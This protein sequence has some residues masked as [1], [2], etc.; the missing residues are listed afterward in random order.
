MSRSNAGTAFPSN[1]LPLQPV[2]ENLYNPH[3][4]AGGSPTTPPHPQSDLRSSVGLGSDP[5][6][7]LNCQ[8]VSAGI[9][10]QGVL[11]LGSL[12][13]VIR[14]YARELAAVYRVPVEL[15][16]I[17]MLGTLSAAIG[18]SRQAINAVPE[19]ITRA[20]L[21]LLVSLSSGA[22][23]SIS[24]RIAKPFTDFEVNATDR[25]E[26][27]DQPRLKSRQIVLEDKLKCLKKASKSAPMEAPQVEAIV[28]ELNQLTRDMEKSPVLS[29]GNFTTTGLGNELA[30]TRDETL[31]VFSSEGG[32]IVDVMLGESKTRA[33]HLQLW[34]N[35][36]SGEGYSQVRAVLSGGGGN[37]VSLKDICLSA[38]LMVQ[39]SVAKKLM[40]HHSARER[41]LLGR[42]LMVEVKAPPVR[43]TGDRLKVSP[44]IEARWTG[45]V[46]RIMEQRQ[47]RTEPLNIS[48][49]SEA[50]EAF[51]TFHNETYCEWSQGDL[52]DMDKELSRW[53][54]NAIKLALILEAA[55]GPEVPEITKE[56]AADAVVLMR[57]IGIGTL[58]L[59]EGQR[60]E[61]FEKRALQLEKALK[62]RSG[63]CLASNLE[64][65]H[66]FSLQ[67][68]RQLA[69]AFPRQFVVAP[70]QSGGRP[71]NIVRLI[72]QR[73][74][75]E[76]CPLSQVSQAPLACLAKNET[77]TAETAWGNLAPSRS[78]SDTGS[79]RVRSNE[80]TLAI[81]SP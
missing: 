71:G 1:N 16:A 28:R 76:G 31:W 78:V 47:Q 58:H 45:L 11:P 30:R 15:P 77:R 66:G 36:Y 65:R 57:W 64:K 26:R 80:A 46:S 20:N 63:E 29:V 49:T 60:Y 62:S 9:F 37:S 12:P 43:D 14:D 53:R 5:Q 22:G 44:E 74:T 73:D 40:E 51:R 48:C 52:C 54:E 19:R 3:D 8:E 21:Y 69:Q 18:K 6:E 67:E 35:G 41:G 68:A 70:V 32:Q 17:C 79:L 72:C 50:V 39:P 34:L 42:M 4:S 33:P 75:A 10:E 25:H 55:K 24:N 7:K 56:I 23:K 38:L 27:E 81:C 61:R 59:F 2:M 13:S